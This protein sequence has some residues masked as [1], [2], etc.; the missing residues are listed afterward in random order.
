[1]AVRRRP[2]PQLLHLHQR[3]R[4]GGRRLSPAVRER[5]AVGGRGGLGSGR[6]EERKQGGAEARRSGSVRSFHSST[7]PLF[8]SPALDRRRFLR[9]L[10]LATGAAAGLPLLRE[11]DAAEPPKPPLRVVIVGA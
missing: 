3:R 6:V 8:H 5:G 1:M 11:L 9:R 2:R 4:T 7:P 10:G